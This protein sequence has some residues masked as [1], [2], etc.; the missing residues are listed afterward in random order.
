MSLKEIFRLENSTIRTW[1]RS[2]NLVVASAI[3]L[4]TILMFT[5]LAV[6]FGKIT[7]QLALIMDLDEKTR[8]LISIVGTSLFVILTL[9]SFVSSI[10]DVVKLMRY[11]LSNWSDDDEQARS[12][13]ASSEN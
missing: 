12:P 4:L 9:L 3:N 10:A 6:G 7:V 8:Q 13:G 11:H 5:L 1:R 2:Y